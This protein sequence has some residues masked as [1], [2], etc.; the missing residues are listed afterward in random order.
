MESGKTID[1]STREHDK[2]NNFF[3]YKNSEFYTDA[4]Y[5]KKKRVVITGIGLIC[6]SGN[7]E[8]L[9][10]D[11]LQGRTSI[12]KLQ[13]KNIR[14]KI[15]DIGGEIKSELNDCFPSR[16]NSY[17]P[18]SAKLAGYALRDCIKDSGLTEYHNSGFIYGTTSLGLDNF[19]SVYKTFIENV[20]MFD[21]RKFL[22]IS[23][24]GIVQFLANHFK[25]RGTSKAILKASNSGLNTL[26][27]GVHTIQLGLEDRVFCVSIE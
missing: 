26:I 7:F 20:E 1:A 14:T 6:S 5:I 27:E 9:W 22:C 23:P 2:Q 15:T 18:R 12:S 25:I 16:M 21:L 17:L 11:V 4:T 10:G 24:A 13:R 19:I 8:S 3:G